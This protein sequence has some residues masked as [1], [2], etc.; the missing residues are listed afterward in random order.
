[1]LTLNLPFHTGALERVALHG[2]NSADHPKQSETTLHGLALSFDTGGRLYQVASDQ[3]AQ[4]SRPGLNHGVTWARYRLPLPGGISVEQQIMV[5]ADGDGVAMSWRLVGRND[6]AVRLHA[7]PI[8]SSARDFA[9]GGFAVELPARGGR[10]TWQPFHNS[11][12]I[13]ADSNGHFVVGVGTLPTGIIPGSFEFE[14][15]RLPA[16]LI[17]CAE[18]HGATVI[19]PLIGGF[20]AQL[21]EERN[22]SE[23]ENLQHHYI[24]A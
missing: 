23:R 8:F 6:A 24:A 15:G 5:P 2:S 20:L 10:L 22:V 17:F 18:Q 9:V 12:Q 4:P 11:S 3:P 1:M 21:S 7:S 16:V 19:N 14:L 13:I